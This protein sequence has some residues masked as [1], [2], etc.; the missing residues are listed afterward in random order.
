M[1]KEE[2]KKTSVS[3]EDE[4]KQVKHLDAHMK[5]NKV[6]KS[7]YEQMDAL[8]AL[9]TKIYEFNDDVKKQIS[10]LKSAKNE[11]V[12]IQRRAI[13]EM[14]LGDTHLEDALIRY[15]RAIQYLKGKE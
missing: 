9:F 10:E 3:A 8:A 6:S 13:Y 14:S 7:N 11:D 1:E 5:L 12:A 15:S 2:Y 4:T